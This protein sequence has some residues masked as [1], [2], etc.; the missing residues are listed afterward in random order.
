MI[1]LCKL[2]EFISIFFH[3]II[4]YRWIVTS[5]YALHGHK[6]AMDLGFQ[7][8]RQTMTSTWSDLFKPLNCTVDY[9]IQL[10]MKPDIQHKEDTIYTHSPQSPILSVGAYQWIELKCSCCCNYPEQW[11]QITKTQLAQSISSYQTVNNNNKLAEL[12]PNKTTVKATSTTLLYKI[13]SSNGH[14]IAL[15]LSKK[16]HSNIHLYH[17]D[18]ATIGSTTYNNYVNNN[19]NPVCITLYLEIKCNAT[20]GFYIHAENLGHSQ[21]TA[22]L[23]WI[24][25]INSTSRKHIESL[26]KLTDSVGIIEEQSNSIGSSSSSSGTSTTVSATTATTTTITTGMAVITSPGSMRRHQKQLQEETLYQLSGNK[27]FIDTLDPSQIKI[28][29]AKIYIPQQIN[30]DMTSTDTNDSR[31]NNHMDSTIDDNGWKN[32]LSLTVLLRPQ[33]FYI[34]SDWSSAVIAFMLAL[35]VGCCDDPI[36]VREQLHESKAIVTGLFCQLILNPMISLGLGLSFGLDVDQAFGLFICST[37][38]A[39]GLAYLITYLSHGDR[40]LSAALSLVASLTDLVIMPFWAVTIGWYWFNRPINIGKTFG[41]LILVASAQSLGTLMRGFRPGLARAILTW[42]TRPLLLLSGILLITLGVYINHYA[43]NEVTQNLIFALLSLNTCGFVVGWLVGLSTSQS[44]ARSRA[45]STVSSVFNGL[46]CIPLLRT[47]V[48]APEGDLAA[49]AALWTVLFSPIPLA[50]HAI[51]TIVEKWLKSYLQ[52]RKK[53]REE[54]CMATILGEKQHELGAASVAAVAVAAIAVT[55]AITTR[56]RSNNTKNSDVR[57]ERIINNENRIDGARMEHSLSTKA[58]TDE[59]EM[60]ISP[61]TVTSAI[62]VDDPPFSAPTLNT[63]EDNA[64]QRGAHGVYNEYLKAAGDELNLGSLTI[65]NTS[66][67]LQSNEKK[68]PEF[69]TKHM[70]DKK[71]SW[72]T[73]STGLRNQQREGDSS[74]EIGKLTLTDS[75]INN[76]EDTTDS[77]MLIYRNSNKSSI[78]HPSFENKYL[79]TIDIRRKLKRVDVQ[80]SV[81]FSRDC[82]HSTGT[83]VSPLYTNL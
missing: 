43:F 35:S 9:H 19:N 70:R 53:R 82:H 8:Q 38:P 37:I 14:V 2:L 71:A 32:Y 26:T 4:F 13:T 18:N 42:I 1:N 46:L 74:I 67:L 6:V 7:H 33:R 3:F 68:L 69:I 79:P 31:I 10:G 64:K 80:P 29:D 77:R 16:V 34:A 17:C 83:T 76:Q 48:H 30:N 21:I 15:S 20:N 55:P 66:P 24:I 61:C 49:V 23:I 51:V 75:K 12:L 22:S 57:L 62:S 65:N 44:C 41:W 81:N 58:V 50:Y 52:N 40:Q 11:K 56:S 59:A 63:S 36:M 28:T 27:G 5:C 78:E 45:L 54:N 39:G 47:C 72:I 60:T 73:E 25:W